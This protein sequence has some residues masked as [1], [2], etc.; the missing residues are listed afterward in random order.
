[1]ELTNFDYR[2]TNLK[3]KGK[4]NVKVTF[5]YLNHK[6]TYELSLKE[7]N[8]FKESDYLNEA[9]EIISQEVKSGKLEKYADKYLKKHNIKLPLFTDF[10]YSLVP[11]SLEGYKEVQVMFNYQNQ[12]I[13][14]Y[15]FIKEAANKGKE[16]YLS[17]AEK[18]I[19]QEAKDG[20]LLKEVKKFINPKSGGGSSKGAKVALACVS[21]AAL[22]LGGLFVYE[23]I[24]TP[25]DS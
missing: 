19:N 17:E 25:T 6:V 23:L 8:K 21:V 5:D 12:R 1:M 3:Q 15:A 4:K 13:T 16:Y 20:S 10:E 14:T 7:N 18:K 2:I 24:K 11:S 22:A 9:K